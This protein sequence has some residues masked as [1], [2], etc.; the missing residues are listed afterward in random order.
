[1]AGKANIP[2]HVIAA[3]GRK[4]NLLDGSTPTLV[5]GFSSIMRLE[6]DFGTLDQAFGVLQG[7]P[8]ITSIAKIMCAGL[9]HESTDH[10]LLSDLDVLRHLLDSTEIEAYSTAIG[11]AFEL[12]FPTAASDDD[13]D[14]T[15][16]ADS[17]LGQTGSTPRLSSSDEPTQSSGV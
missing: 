9:E 1:M 8:S 13:A 10:G 3:R 17:S 7:A 14:P 16:G 15:E 2:A 12:S 4:I 6:E 5:F 11:E